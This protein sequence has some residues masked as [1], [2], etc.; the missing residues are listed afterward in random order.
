MLQSLKRY[1]T[2][3]FVALILSGYFFFGF[4][5]LG[6]FI[7]ADEHYWVYERIPQYW[8][9][10]ADGKWRK[11]IIN[12]KPGVTLALTAGA[13]LLAVPDPQS[14][15]SRTEERIITCDTAA[16]EN[17]LFIFRL[18]ILGTNAFLLL[19]LFWIIQKITNPII[20]LWSVAFMALSPILVGISQ[21]VN[22]D[23]LLWSLG[24]ASLFSYFALL[25]FQEKKFL[26]FTGVFLGFAVLSKYTASLLLPF[27]LLITV[28][29]LISSPSP[30]VQ[31]LRVSLKHFLFVVLITIATI[32]IFLPAAWF[33][34]AIIITLLSGG[35]ETPFIL[36]TLLCFVLFLLDNIL[37]TGR[38]Y[39]FF[40][41]IVEHIKTFRFSPYL[42]PWGLLSLC[43][44]LLFGKI[45]FPHWD[46]FLTIPFD[47]KDLTSTYNGIDIAPNIFESLLLETRPLIFALAP[48]SLFFFI[49]ILARLPLVKKKN[50]PWHLE[51]LL[52]TLFVPLFIFILIFLDVLA[53]P[54]YII[55]LYPLVAFLAACGIW[56][57][58][59]FLKK[60]CPQYA[61]LDT[62]HVTLLLI[63]LLSISLITSRPFY[64]NYTNPLLPKQFLISDAWGYGGYEA[65][66][67]LNTLPNAQNLLV[68]TDYEGVC[69]FFVGKCMLKQYKY[70]SKQQIDY[71]V[72]TRRGGILYN[73]NHSRWAKEGNLSM[74]QAYDNPDPGWQLQIGG[75]PENFIK[76]VKV[77][78][79]L[80]VAIITDIDHCPSRETVSEQYLESF[81]AFSQEKEVDF[82]MSLGDNASHRLRD[83]STTGDADARYIAERLRSSEKPV[84][85]A[86]GDHD[87]SSSVTSYRN[88]LETIGREKTY[89]SFYTNNVHVIVLD[90]VLGGD[91]LRMGCVDDP[92]C[93]ELEQRLT[94][95]KTLTFKEYQ[96]KYS[97]ALASQ[98]EERRAVTNHWEKT[99]QDIALTRSFGNRDR[100]RIGEEELAWLKEDIGK[101][102][103]EKILIFS[104]H[105]L[106]PFTSAKKQY[107]VIDGEKVREILEQS[108]KEMVAI[109]GEAHLWHEEVLNGIQYYIVDEFRKQ[110]GSFAHFSWDENGFRLDKITH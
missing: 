105:P 64:F 69:E 103:L 49:L 40:H 50:T 109:S 56:E 46:L 58:R 101:T 86:L 85:L 30:T 59:Q 15:C 12:D 62:F 68:W 31:Q 4:Q 36:V 25:R 92:H 84:H 39:F 2:A 72:L 23:A 94:D 88:W 89:Y 74:K 75:R 95:I 83:C 54:R 107:D 80:D 1:H 73:P 77:D 48:L 13:G 66:Q 33:K 41:R 34:P 93:S 35:T 61:L 47:A 104:D 52:T 6:K 32:A 11:T 22:P 26:F 44:F 98:R 79:V 63:L 108:G 67:Y 17:M 24:S 19:F 8:D 91:E 65:A 78:N 43:L 70:S 10:L 102:P 16:T 99:K 45:F 106:F 76:V 57:S 37:F 55:L 20:A 5:H 18:F 97:D 9:A 3:L 71:A 96:N 7:T 82:I 51:I 42:L 81:I 38:A 90:T 29:T 53:T 60:R 87:I 28:A 100:G 21:I 110:N 27:F 14:L